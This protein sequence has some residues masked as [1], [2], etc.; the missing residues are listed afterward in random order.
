MNAFLV[1]RY[2]AF[3]LYI[4][5]SALIGS[6]SALNMGY[7]M[8]GTKVTS[9]GMIQGIDTYLLILSIVNMV[10]LF[11]VIGIE[12]V[13]R[14]ALTSKI[15]FELLW[16]VLFLLAFLGGAVVATLNYPD[17]M[18]SKAGTGEGSC[19][20]AIILIAIAWMTTS[21][22][23]IYLISL[24]V[25]TFSQAKH[26]HNIWSSSVADHGRHPGVP[27]PIV[28]SQSQ[29]RSIDSPTTLI[30]VYPLKD[31]SQS[32]DKDEEKAVAVAPSLSANG[33]PTFGAGFTFPKRPAPSANRNIGVNAIN[34]A[35]SYD[36][37]SKA[38]YQFQV[39]SYR[40]GQKTSASGMEARPAPWSQEADTPSPA[41][42]EHV[43]RVVSVKPSLYPAHV[44][45]AG[46]NTHSRQSV[47]QQQQIG[48]R[49]QPQRPGQ[50]QPMVV[51]NFVD[52]LR[53][54]GLNGS[55]TSL[56]YARSRSS[57]ASNQSRT[58]TLTEEAPSTT[59]GH[60][61]AQSVDSFV[62][63][64]LATPNGGSS[65]PVQN[66]TGNSRRS[67]S[68][69]SNHFTNNRRSK[70]IRRPPPLN[71]NGLSNIAKADRRD[72]KSVV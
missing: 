21:L 26:T 40:G 51:G 45:S 35:P 1:V 70:P 3:A 55:S 68:E 31:D 32:I 34:G 29:S 10:F 36:S 28:V 65:T 64:S 43:S 42:I 12:L 8:N 17:T 20:T 58:P 52:I 9:P 33:P 59:K 13:R 60:T 47:Q 38:P 46:L 44:V 37:N 5:F 57:V 27:G 56:P 61:Q 71:L 30:N 48:Q 18:C 19:L 7:L 24:V 67:M 69:G 63:V 72:R 25:Y 50:Q 54:A 16:N 6:F 23:L 62:Q 53:A 15:W 39:H 2:G 66:R 14:G 11:P 41:V 49:T 4:V 22:Y